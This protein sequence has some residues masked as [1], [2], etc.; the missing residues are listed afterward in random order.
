MATKKKL[1]TLIEEFIDYKLAL[2][3][4]KYHGKLDADKVAEIHKKINSIKRNIDAK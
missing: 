3:T 2:I 4:M 1:S